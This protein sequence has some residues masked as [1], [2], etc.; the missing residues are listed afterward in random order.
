MAAAFLSVG[1]SPAASLPQNPRDIEK[2]L[3]NRPLHWSPPLIDSSLRSR[4]SS[5]A[6]ALDTA[7]EQA[8]AR[9]TELV[10]NLQNFTAQETLNYQA[11]DRLGDVREGASGTFDY[12]VVF[13]QASGNMV[14]QE[15]RNPSH[16]SRLSLAMVQ[17][18]GLPE[19]ALMFLPEMQSDYKMSCEG[20]VEVN[21]QP[22]WV[23]HFEQR[24]DK[25]ARTLSFRGSRSVYPARLKG[26]AW[27]AANSGEVVRIETSLMEEIPDAN[28]RHWFLVLDYAPVQFRTRNVKIWLPQTVD[29]YCEFEAYRSIAY[30]TFTDFLLFSVQTEQKIENPQ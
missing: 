19:I 23:V 27:I 13:Q 11:L 28:V 20:T 17:D 30:H 26:R 7:L 8:G 6:C 1:A 25:P 5:P 12:V 3:K 21:A 24:K 4:I 14:I 22:T 15:N 16:A 2:K 18:V 29:A 10:A 9:A